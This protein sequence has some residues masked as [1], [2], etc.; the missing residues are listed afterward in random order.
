ML[1]P[2]CQKQHPGD[3]CPSCGRHPGTYVSFPT[4][5]EAIARL[6]KHV[7]ALEL[8]LKLFEEEMRLFITQHG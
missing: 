3:T 6:E 8:K 1:C 4:E 7:A 2:I 5:R